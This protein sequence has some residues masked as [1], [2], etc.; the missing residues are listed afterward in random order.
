M[1]DISEHFNSDGSINPDGPGL[2][3]LAG[4]DHADSQSYKDAKDFPS[5]VKAAYD[6]HAMVGKKL[7]NVI[8]KPGGNATEDE[9]KAYRTTLNKARGA[10]ESGSEYEFPRPDGVPYNEKR[11]AEFRELLCKGGVPKDTAKMIWDWH[12]GNMVTDHTAGKE[13][14]AT[15]ETVKQDKLRIDWPGDAMIEKP[16]LAY[17]AIQELGP[18]LLPDAWEDFKGP[19][20]NTIKGIKSMMAEEKIY[21]SPG[22]LAK[23]NKIGISVDTLKYYE[24]LGRRMQIKPLLTSE[25]SAGSGSLS[26]TEEAEKNRINAENRLS[27][28]MQV[29]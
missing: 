27:P 26:D 2:H 12:N 28:G 16:R 19:D 8:Q 11:E 24:V 15:A 3:T 25:G 5:F 21:D 4:P 1:F 17:N 29:K 20:G 9:T 7:D 23:W 6:T 10:P 22:D 14:A 18:D 13:A